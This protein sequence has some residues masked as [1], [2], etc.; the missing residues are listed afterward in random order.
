M[1]DVAAYLCHG[2]SAL[3][4]ANATR[5]SMLSQADEVASAAADYARRQLRPAGVRSA[6]D[7]VGLGFVVVHDVILKRCAAE[8]TL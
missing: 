6:A 4:R 1:E 3:D 2:R 5:L 8:A 7:K